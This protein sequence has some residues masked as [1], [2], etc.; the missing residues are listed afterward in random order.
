MLSE[1]LSRKYLCL[2]L[3]RWQ[4]GR[5]GIGDDSPT[6]GHDAL[7]R[8]AGNA[9]ASSAPTSSISAPASSTSARSSLLLCAAPA[10]LLT[11]S[12]VVGPAKRRLEQVPPIDVIASFLTE[13]PYL[14]AIQSPQ[15]VSRTHERGRQ[16][17]VHAYDS[18]GVPQSRISPRRARLSRSPSHVGWAVVVELCLPVSDWDVPV[19][20]AAALPNLRNLQ[21]LDLCG[22]DAPQKDFFSRLVRLAPPLRSV[23]LS[24]SAPHTS[25]ASLLETFPGIIHLELVVGPGR[26]LQSPIW[27]TLRLSTS[28]PAPSRARIAP[29]IPRPGGGR[30]QFHRCITIQP[31]FFATT[32]PGVK[33]RMC[34]QWSNLT[35]HELGVIDLR[36]ERDGETLG[37]DDNDD[38]DDESRPPSHPPKSAQLCSHS[39]PAQPSS[40]RPRSASTDRPSIWGAIPTLLVAVPVL[41]SRSAQPSHVSP[42]KVMLRRFADGTASGVVVQKSRQTDPAFLLQFLPDLVPTINPRLIDWIRLKWIRPGTPSGSS[43]YHP[44]CNPH[45]DSARLVRAKCMA[46][47]S[48]L[49]RH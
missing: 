7:T 42:L 22:E 2:L 34:K 48:I 21:L 13:C 19:P 39:K 27:P 26:S 20:A 31:V 17:G 38:D 29:Q 16:S 35:G 9:F 47:A 8:L 11:L 49:P 3:K 6:G 41:L 28:D 32:F 25:L 36:A 1:R 43:E 15:P 30:G 33:I 14:V 24:S 23:S 18:A 12:F 40:A 46:S 45:K 44:H 37:R 10:A 5:F 4:D